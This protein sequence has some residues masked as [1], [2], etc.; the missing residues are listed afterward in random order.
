MSRDFCEPAEDSVLFAENLDAET[1][2]SVPGVRTVVVSQVLRQQRI[3]AFATDINPHATWCTKEHVGIND[4]LG[5][6]CFLR[7]A[8]SSP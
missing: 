5:K 8:C 2:A 3:W 6:M 1:G 7:Q 4:V